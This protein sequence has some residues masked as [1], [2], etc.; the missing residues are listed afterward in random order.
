[1]MPMLDNDGKHDDVMAM[2]VMRLVMVML[3]VLM[4]KLW[5][6]TLAAASDLSCGVL[7]PMLQRRF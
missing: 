3:T 2:M 7:R 4:V 1:M 5:H 6:R